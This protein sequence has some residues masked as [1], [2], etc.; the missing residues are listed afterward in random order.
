[1]SNEITGKYYEIKEINKQTRKSK[2]SIANIVSMAKSH[3]KTGILNIEIK[4]EDKIEN[5]ILNENNN[6][7]ELRDKYSKKYRSYLHEN[8]VG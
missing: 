6:I 7:E 4:D 5:I 3:N 8:R 1:M 2:K